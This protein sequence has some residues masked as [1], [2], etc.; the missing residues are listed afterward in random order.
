[1]TVV[2]S[3]DPAVRAAAQALAARLLERTPRMRSSIN[4][5]DAPLLLIATAQ[6]LDAFL[7]RNRLPPRPREVAAPELATK[8][9]AQVWVTRQPNG[10]ALAV[11]CAA[12]AAALA[13]LQRPLPHYGR[14]SWLVFQGAQA[15]ERG[16]WPSQP[17]AWRFPP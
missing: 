11:I 1:V 3:E 7:E 2:P 6:E 12:D 9:S 5:E 15:L 4:H 14:Q 10:K 17:V 8:A 16:V 13:A